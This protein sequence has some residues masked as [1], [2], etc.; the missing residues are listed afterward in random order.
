MIRIAESLGATGIEI[1]VRLTKDGVPVLYHDGSLNPR[2]TQKTALVGGVEDYTFMQLRSAIRLINGER[3]P[4][5]QEALD[6]T[7]EETN[8]AFVWLD[9]KTEGR[10]IVEVMAP[11]QAD[12][13][14]RA[15]AM[16]RDL[17]VRI[18]MP[19]QEVYDEV[20][21]YPG[22]TDLPTLCELSIDQARIA[23]SGVWAPRW[24]EGTQNANV[25]AMHAEGRDAFVWTLDA[26]EYINQFLM[27]GDFDGFLT[28]YPSAVAY[29]YY[30]Q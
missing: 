5:L 18:G 14:A 6:V 20:L 25:D 28:N 22:Y 3:I 16:G 15:Q 17:E 12:I 7:L 23:N 27:Q 11:I 13:L 4:T 21:R 2:L 24:T 30:S 29:Y 19:T 1:D 9:T 10:N 8:L 26:P